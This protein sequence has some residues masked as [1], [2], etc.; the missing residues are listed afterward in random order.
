MKIDKK[1]ID[2]INEY[3]LTTKRQ[4]QI[5]LGIVTDDFCYSL[6]N[7]RQGFEHETLYVFAPKVLLQDADDNAV[8]LYVYTKFNIIET[9]RGDFTVV[10]SFH[11]LNRPIQFAFK[12]QNEE[13]NKEKKM[14]DV[15]QRKTA[16]CE[17][18]RDY[19]EYVVEDVHLTGKLKGREY[20]YNGKEARCAVCGQLVFVPDIN[21]ENLSLLYGEYQKEKTA[22]SQRNDVFLD[23]GISQYALS[24]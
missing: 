5:L 9:R 15:T 3:N 20:G 6:K 24:I 21:D 19:T 18:C 2:F 22:C 14:K 7:K 12:T 10:I 16:F 1:N 8:S 4:R 13:I 11:K 17:E 23:T